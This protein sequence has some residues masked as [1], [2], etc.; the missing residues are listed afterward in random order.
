[1]A[2][3]SR[4]ERGGSNKP[5]ARVLEAEGLVIKDRAGKVRIRL[6]C[7]V[8]GCPQIQLFDPD[9]RPRLAAEVDPLGSQLV[10]FG[11]QG[12]RRV[13]VRHG[14][15]GVSMVG[16][17]DDHGELTAGLHS[18]PGAGGMLALSD[19][20]GQQG[21]GLR[22]NPDGG[23]GFFTREELHPT[24]GA[25]CPGAGCPGTPFPHAQ[26][27]NCPHPKPGGSPSQN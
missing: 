2:N 15:G 23:M 25:G 13:H 14:P 5:P 18:P 17:F 11:E 3:R 10:L 27:S 7:D 21:A 9:G 4:K 16:L 8:D 1:M 6:G 26:G 22:V 19:A 20:S 24:P 12:E